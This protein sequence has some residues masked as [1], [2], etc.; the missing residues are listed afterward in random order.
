[1]NNLC[2][3]VSFWKNTLSEIE[4][5]CSIRDEKINLAY[6]ILHWLYYAQGI[7]AIST[8]LAKSKSSYH[9]LIGY[10]VIVILSNLYAV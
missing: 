6:I 3:K 7:N 10:F 4:I 1:M 5:V 8:P 2:P 9:H